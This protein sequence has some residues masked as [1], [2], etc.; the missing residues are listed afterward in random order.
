MQINNKIDKSINNE[1]KLKEKNIDND[2][3]NKLEQ[4]FQKEIDKK[5]NNQ[6]K[7]R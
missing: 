5:I 1:S 6:D 3:N 4:D 7:K 2:N